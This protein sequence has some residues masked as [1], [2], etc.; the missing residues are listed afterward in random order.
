MALNFAPADLRPAIRRLVETCGVDFTRLRAQY[1]PGAHA[2][3]QVYVNWWLRRMRDY[4]LQ[5]LRQANR[6]LAALNEM[7][8]NEPDLQHVIVQQHH[9][10]MAIISDYQELTRLLNML[11]RVPNNVHFYNAVQLL[12]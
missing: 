4:T 6:Q 1:F 2:P 10:L 7:R 3:T 12:G 8:M 9:R 5:K 11:Q